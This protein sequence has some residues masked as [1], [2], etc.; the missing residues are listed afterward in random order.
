MRKGQVLGFLNGT[1][2]GVWDRYTSFGARALWWFLFFFPPTSWLNKVVWVGRSVGVVPFWVRRWRKINWAFDGSSAMKIEL[3][4]LEKDS[5]SLA[6][7]MNRSYLGVIHEEVG[8]E[9][10]WISQL[11][12]SQ[13]PSQ[14]NADSRYFVDANESFN[15]NV[16]LREHKIN[17]WIMQIILRWLRRW[18]LPGC[19][20]WEMKCKLHACAKYNWAPKMAS[21]LT[22]LT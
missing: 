6:K 2:R 3:K 11:G 18:R 4:R 19:L 10:N 7:K 1:I 22:K 12:C 16:H 14:M 9:E 17:E 20:C 8:A 21:R 5:S 13:F 15:N